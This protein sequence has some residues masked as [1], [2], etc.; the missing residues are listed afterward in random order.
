MKRYILGFV[1]SLITF[2]GYAQNTVVVH[3]GLSTQEFL[4]TENDSITHSNDDNVNIHNNSTTVSFPVSSID[5]ISVLKN[6]SEFEYLYITNVIDWSIINASHSGYTLLSIQ[7]EKELAESETNVL[8]PVIK[9][10]TPQIMLLL[11]ADGDIV[12]MSKTVFTENGQTNI[13]DAHSTAIALVTMHP[14]FP[15]VHGDDYETLVQIITS[16]RYFAPL[17]EEVQKIVE[18]GKSPLVDNDDVMIALGT[19]LEEL[20]SENEENVKPLE[21]LRENAPKRDVRPINIAD[22][23]NIGPLDMELI[24]EVLYIR[25]NFATPAYEGV[26]STPNGNVPFNI[27]AGPNHGIVNWVKN[28]LTPNDGENGDVKFDF[29][30]RAE[31]EYIFNFDRTTL[32]GTLDFA[33]RLI[34]DILDVVGFQLS[35]RHMRYFTDELIKQVGV[36]SIA[37][38][39]ALL[40]DN[41]YKAI[42]WCT[43]AVLDFLSTPDGI[44]FL[45]KVGLSSSA[46]SF[47][48]K[49]SIVLAVYQG[50]MGGAN[51]VLRITTRIGSPEKITYRLCHYINK[52]SPCKRVMLDIMSGNN[53]EGHKGEMLKEYLKVKIRSYNDDGIEIEP[54]HFYQVK[55]EVVSGGG[56]LGYRAEYQDAYYGVADNYWY[57]GREV[58]EQKVRAVVVD[59]ATKEEISDPV[60]F[61]ATVLETDKITFCLNWNYTMHDTD[62]DL[63]VTCPKGHH[64]YYY[65]MSC[66]C[67]G[68]LDR[69]DRQG[70]GPEHV[71]FDS[72]VPGDYI[73]RVHHYESQNGGYAGYKLTAYYNSYEEQYQSY[74]SVRY[75][76]WSRKYRFRVPESTSGARRQIEITEITDEDFIYPTDLPKKEGE[77]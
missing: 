26:V 70:P 35:S 66:P 54:N 37:S 69:D 52:T 10:E 38:G 7:Q 19:L 55:F 21:I 24:G 14:I 59:P 12:M 48:S 50:G 61:T 57:L 77:Q 27:P 43:S 25:T 64:I 63:H 11:N 72:A 36:G 2:I 62:I 28:W 56:R 76:D 5:S 23:T 4:L 42:E 74:G 40:S 1:V 73:V 22:I 58:T 34:A 13:I 15:F 65:S 46:I 67:G 68:R 39:S 45:A 44:I 47:I 6:S 30:G 51:A 17:E 75:H 53:Q 49:A 9:S 20:T 71:V 18:Q 60:F 41:P 16:S 29:S 32:Y 31:G 8:T 33:S 3:Q